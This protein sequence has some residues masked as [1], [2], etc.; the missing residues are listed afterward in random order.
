LDIFRKRRQEL[1]RRGIPAD[2]PEAVATTWDISFQQLEVVSPE[3]TALL[4]FCAF[5]APEDIP[6]DLFPEGATLFPKPL[7]RIAADP[8]AL[9]DAVA[10]A[11]RLSLLEVEDEALSLHRLVQ[12]A[13]R[14]SCNKSKR[15]LWVTAAVRCL[16][17]AYSFDEGRI[18]TWPRFRRLLP[19]ALAVAEHAEALRAEIVPTALLLRETGFYLQK[20][21]AFGSVRAIYPRFLALTAT[22]ALELNEAI[23]PDAKKFFLEALEITQK[24][25]GQ[26]HPLT[27]NF[28]ANLAAFEKR[29][30]RPVK[31]L[32][33]ALA[34]ILRTSG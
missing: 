31:R 25:Y 20:R 6:L 10:A 18:E 30:K 16:T 3:A 4:H 12:A 28:A 15:K 2:Y 8:V 7:A 5:L 13:V 17:A 33:S 9:R 22:A 26:D 27:K 14:D 21:D 24:I 34:Q 32:L 23:H 1:L 11:R 29:A 19:H